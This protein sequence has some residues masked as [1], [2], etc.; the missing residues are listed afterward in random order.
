MKF[1]RLNDNVIRCVISKEEMYDYGIEISEI[2]DNRDKAEDFLRKVMQE[3]RYE[4]N[5]KT[6]GGALSVQIAVLPEGDVAMTIAEALPEKIESQMN[7]LK[8]YLE[9]FQK[10]LDQK[11][12]EKKKSE[13]KEESKPG[14]VVKSFISVT[15]AVW[16]RCDSMDTCMDIA[17]IIDENVIRSSALYTYKDEYYYKLEIADGEKIG[18]LF[19]S[20]CEY[21]EEI[22]LEHEGA[23]MIY[24]H[25]R[26]LIAKDAIA[27]LR[28]L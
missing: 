20:F 10:V 23:V 7:I 12:S 8:H 9:D 6:Q 1:T 2:V 11:I 24:E 13:S 25:G 28:N 15:E 18:E 5:Y 19:L 14:D 17:N 27:T 4:L 3:A 26:C 22:F 21:G 16:V